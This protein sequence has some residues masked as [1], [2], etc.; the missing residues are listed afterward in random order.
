MI[1][2]PSFSHTQHTLR[3]HHSQPC[4][5]IYSLNAHPNP[6]SI[7]FDECHFLNEKN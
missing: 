1:I 5:S 3:W 2:I 4:E 6:V 7:S